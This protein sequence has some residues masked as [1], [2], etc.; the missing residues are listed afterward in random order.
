MVN[1]VMA[2]AVT[3]IDDELITD[4]YTASAKKKSRKP[5]YAL[6]SIAACLV[7]VF[8]AVLLSAPNRTQVYL[9]GEKITHKPVLVSSPLSE[10]FISPRVSPE[11]TISL[12]L[13]LGKAETRI[14]T[15]EG[16]FTLCSI[17]QDTLFYEGNDYIADKS[18]AKKECSLYWTIEN[19]DSENTYTLTLE[20][21][22]TRILRLK[23]DENQQNWMIFIEK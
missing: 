7:L 19:P 17:N 10:A 9:Q 5:L 16:K 23:Y 13:D 21:K 20:D 1:E 6:V 11:L 22:E 8:T 12:T 2:R 15:S 4:D 18:T 3:G 14:Y